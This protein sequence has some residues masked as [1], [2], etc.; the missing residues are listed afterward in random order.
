MAKLLTF[1]MSYFDRTPIG[2][3]VTRVISDL[4]AITE[5]FSSG[6][7]T[8]LGDLITLLVVITTMCFMNFQLT[9]M[10][11]IPIPI[12][13]IATRVFARVVRGTLQ[14]EQKQVTRLNTFVQERLTGMSLVRM[15]NREKVEFEAFKE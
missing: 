6:M 7:M 12:L 13:I 9:L 11:L 5:V 14:D 2:A 4:E 3:T 10:V 1:K 15:F 8:I